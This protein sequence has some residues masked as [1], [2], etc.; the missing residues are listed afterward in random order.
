M[1]RDVKSHT[2]VIAWQEKKKKW[3]QV[4]VIQV[5]TTAFKHQKPLSSLIYK[6]RYTDTTI[7][8]EGN[9]SPV[10]I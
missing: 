4:P 5:S 7:F 8:W 10:K 6:R 2:E 3:T 9:L 1:L